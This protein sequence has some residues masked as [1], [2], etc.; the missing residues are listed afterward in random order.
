MVRLILVLADIAASVAVMLNN[1][2]FTNTLGIEWF[3]QTELCVWSGQTALEVEQKKLPEPGS[4]DD[5]LGAVV[6]LEPWPPNISFSQVPWLLLVFKAAKSWGE[7]KGR[8]RPQSL[9]S[10]PRFS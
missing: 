10:F 9:L 7:G 3:T 4:G 5:S 1:C 6:F 2:F 8:L